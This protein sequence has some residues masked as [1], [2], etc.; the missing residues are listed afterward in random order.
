MKKYHNDVIH[1]TIA[2]I[3]LNTMSLVMIQ[4]FTSKRPSI[5]T[6]IPL[7]C[8]SMII[9]AGDLMYVL[10]F[11]QWYFTYYDDN[12]VLQKWIAKKK[13]INFNE[14]KFLYFIDNLVI[15]SKSVLDK[16]FEKFNIKEK[17]QIKRILKHEVCILINPYDNLF[18]KM[19]IEKCNHAI[20][21]D[22]KVND[23]KIREMFE[24]D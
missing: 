15:L 9:I 20:K 22:F 11:D 12:H 10:L 17:R 5:D 18:A 13:V 4:F 1:V 2:V 14:V 16:S 6:I 19:I 24:L 7:I 21:R 8:F 23:K 3:L